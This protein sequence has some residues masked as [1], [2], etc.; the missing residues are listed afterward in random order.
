MV[1]NGEAPKP[2]TLAGSVVV[3]IN[4]EKIG[5]V[6]AVVPYL[7]Q[8]ANIGGITMLTDASAATLEVA[9]QNWTVV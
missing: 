2:N 9:P 4:G 3:T 1:P 6:G 5:V 8:I 7:P